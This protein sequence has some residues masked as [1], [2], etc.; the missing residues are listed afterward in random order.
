[1]NKT[2]MLAFLAFFIMWIETKRFRF[3]FSLKKGTLVEIDKTG[4]RQTYSQ[5][6]NKIDEQ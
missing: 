2:M 1:M 4:P 6:K 5:I 3:D